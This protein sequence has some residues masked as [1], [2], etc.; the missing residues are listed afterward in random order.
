[1]WASLGREPSVA[2]AGWPLVDPEL[3]REESV[4]CVV[5]IQGKVRARL[6]VDPNIGEEE[7]QDLALATSAAQEAL[8]GSQ[9]SRIIVRPPR[10]VNIVL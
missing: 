8:A 9:P 6:D 10:V 7:L 3:V 1:M 5:Q 4:T 2:R